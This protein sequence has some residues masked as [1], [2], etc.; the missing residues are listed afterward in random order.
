MKKKPV[1]EDLRIYKTKKALEEALID[2]CREKPFGKIKIKEITERALVSRQTFYLHYET[3]E[4]ILVGYISNQYDRFFDHICHEVRNVHPITIEVVQATMLD[5]FTLN[6][7]FTKLLFEIDNQDIVLDAMLDITLRIHDEFNLHSHLK[8]T[9][10]KEDFD[11]SLKY[12][13]GGCYVLLREWVR[14]GNM[15]YI[16][17]IADNNLRLLNQK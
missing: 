4:E 3:K 8:S 17:A 9:Q 10:S 1:K 16:Q 13:A 7:D 14:N 2:L 15:T 6:K 12:A 5:T 11:N